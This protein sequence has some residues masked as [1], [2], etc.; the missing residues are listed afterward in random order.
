MIKRIIFVIFIL[1][2]ITAIS[3]F[4]YTQKHQSGKVSTLKSKDYNEK[5]T[6]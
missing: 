2:I 3:G 1:L 5:A 4:L 6:R